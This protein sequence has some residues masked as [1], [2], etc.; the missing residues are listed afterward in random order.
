MCGAPGKR[1]HLPVESLVEHGAGVSR[2]NG[3][4]RRGGVARLDNV[5]A[6][7][8][9]VAEAVAVPNAGVC[10]AV[11]CAWDQLPLFDACVEAGRA[12]QVNY[13]LI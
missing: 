6:G 11:L 8:E 5:I 12:G 10:R 9:A 2:C 3:L 1:T 7:D 4:V 13:N